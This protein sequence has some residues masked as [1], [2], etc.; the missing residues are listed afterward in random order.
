MHIVAELTGLSG[1]QLGAFM[2]H[3]RNQF[4]FKDAVMMYLPEATVR[5]NVLDLFETFQYN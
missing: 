5:Q 3:L 2:Q 4:D 1:K